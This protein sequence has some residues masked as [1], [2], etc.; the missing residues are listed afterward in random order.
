[1][2]KSL[3]ATTSNDVWFYID[4]GSIRNIISLFLSLDESDSTQ[5]IGMQILIGGNTLASSTLCFTATVAT[6]SR[7]INCG[8]GIQ[9]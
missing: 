9:G 5:H 1:M 3:I 6:N 4:M 7:W 8:T 2:F